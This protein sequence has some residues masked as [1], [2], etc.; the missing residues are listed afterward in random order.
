VAIIVAPIRVQGE[1]KMLWVA[2]LLCAALMVVIG[3]LA[4][5]VSPLYFAVESGIVVLMGFLTVR[6]S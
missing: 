5:L 2:M 4:V 1:V 3:G 6:S